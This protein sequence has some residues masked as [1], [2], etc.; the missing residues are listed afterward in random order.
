MKKHKVAVVGCGALAQRTHLP[1]CK[2]NP[3]IELVA[4]CDI[5]ADAAQSCKEKFGAQRAET[6]W[7]K[8]VKADDIDLFV[9]ATHTNLRGEFIIPALEAGKGLTKKPRASHA[10]LPDNGPRGTPT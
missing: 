1:H 10:D 8:L 4:A 3:R 5:N 9:L 7:R 6:D 2:E